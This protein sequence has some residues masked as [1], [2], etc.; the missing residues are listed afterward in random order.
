MHRDPLQTLAAA[1]PKLPLAGASAEPITR[2]GSDRTY[3]RIRFADGGIVI[4]MQWTDARPDNRKFIA[5]GQT[6]AR[7]GVPVPEVL[8]DDPESKVIVLQDLG[9][10]HL[11]DRRHDPWPAREKL[12]KAT[13]DEIAK[14]HHV[15]S[16][17]L[18]DYELAALEPPFDAS[19]Y[20]W[21]Q[22]YFF[23]KFLARYSHHSAEELAKLRAAAEF[24]A[25]A[26]GLAALPR[27]LVHRDFQSQNILIHGGRPHFIDYQGLRFGLPEYDIASLLYDPYVPFAADERAALIRHA[28]RGRDP[29]AWRPVF[30]RCATQR[31]VQALGAY[32]R[33]VCEL[34]KVEFAAHIQPALDGLREVLAGD[35]APPLPT[36]QRLIAAEALEVPAIA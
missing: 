21:E 1:L 5:A 34:G 4:L 28:F 31:L 27:H 12:Y 2:G 26:E 7:F 18:D 20:R 8:H 29:A 25:L 23:E 22:G 17:D 6:M 19:I 15:A 35:D 9:E 10:E 3:H 11:W 33:I 36:L 32:G 13:L 16:D 30:N 24:D 14:L